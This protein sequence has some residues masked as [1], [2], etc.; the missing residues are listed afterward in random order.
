MRGFS[1]LLE[2]VYYQLLNILVNKFKSSLQSPLAV[3]YSALYCLGSNPPLLRFGLSFGFYFPV[4]RFLRLW[5]EN[6]EQP[7]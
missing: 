3:T 4:R 6:L 1:A 7:P 5:L 2:L